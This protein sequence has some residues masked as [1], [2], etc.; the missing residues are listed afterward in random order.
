MPL[1]S[2]ASPFH[3]HPILLLLL[4]LLLSLLL[5]LL[6]LLSLLLLLLL[7]LFL[8]VAAAAVAVAAAYAAVAPAAIVSYN[9]TVAPPAAP[10][11]AACPLLGL[12]HPA[13]RPGRCF[14]LPVAG[15]EKNR[16]AE[17]GR[18]AGPSPGGQG[19]AQGLEHREGRMAH[20]T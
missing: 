6:L 11:A 10:G 7:L 14:R 18:P 1:V 3:P 20:V 17:E 13:L 4:L 9:A 12:L 5:L 15:S 8:A 2:D 16:Q 19:G